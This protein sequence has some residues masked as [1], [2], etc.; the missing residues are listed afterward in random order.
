MITVYYSLYQAGVRTRFSR[1][2]SVWQ[3]VENFRLPNQ[4][5]TLDQGRKDSVKG[6]QT[7]ATM[8]SGFLFLL[9]KPEFHSHLASW[10]VHVH[11]PVRFSCCNYMQQPLHS[12]SPSIHNNIFAFLFF[13]IF[14][15]LKLSRMIAQ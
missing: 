10:R 4:K 12:T 6:E 15:S 3:V 1:H 9:A 2:L 5:T 13:I 7:L 8:A 11:T 14:F